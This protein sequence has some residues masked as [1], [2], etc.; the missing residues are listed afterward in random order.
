MRQEVLRQFVSAGTDPDAWRAAW[1]AMRPLTAAGAHDVEFVAIDDDSLEL[2]MP[3]EDHARQPFGLLHGGISMLLAESAASMHACWGVDLT[4]R[5]PVGIEIAGSHLD[6]ASS[7]TIGV[8]ATV[9]SRGRTLARH[10]VLVTH[11]ETGRLLCDARVTNLYR[12]TMG[13]K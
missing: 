6:S 4:E 7:G 13:G 1:E 10:R 8:K 12:P 5:Y 3:L 2:R 11:E 9:V